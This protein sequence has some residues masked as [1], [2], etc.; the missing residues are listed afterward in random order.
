MPATQVQ[1]CHAAPLGFLRTSEHV[2]L[3]EVE[4]TD[5]HAT[6]AASQR[7]RYRCRSC[8]TVPCRATGHGG[9]PDTVDGRVGLAAAATEEARSNLVSGD[10]EEAVICAC[11]DDAA[12][13]YTM[14]NVLCALR[15]HYWLLVEAY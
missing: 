12:A 2:V 6:V 3:A 15:S 1:R 5:K 13:R 8:R 14:M 11:F 4:D 7:P 9:R 10:V